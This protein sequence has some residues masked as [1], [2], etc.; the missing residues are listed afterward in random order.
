[1]IRT[2]VMLASLAAM[3]GCSAFLLVSPDSPDASC[4][5]TRAF[6]KPWH[7]L[8]DAE[9]RSEIDRACGRVFVGFKEEGATR[10]VDLQG[11]SLTSVETVAR[12]K[13]HLAERNI[14]IEWAAI[15][16][17]QVSARMS[18]ELALVTD[19]RR[20]PNVDFVEPLFSG[21]RLGR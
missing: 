8:S 7:E 9:L 15:D 2:L 10:G 18:P 3:A 21:T 20:H 6:S 12:M 19:L 5:G 11:R 17:P 14:T 1:M 4:V 16:L 13:V